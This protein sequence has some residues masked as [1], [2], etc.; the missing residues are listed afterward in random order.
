MADQLAQHAAFDLVDRMNDLIRSGTTD[1]APSLMQVPLEHYNSQERH[2]RELQALFRTTPLCAAPSAA[3]ANPGDFTTRDVLD[4]SLLISRDAEGE[5]HVVLNYCTHRGAII[6]TGEGC[7]KRHSCPYH[8]WTFDPS[9]TLVGLPGAKGFDELDR[10]TAGL[11]KLPTVEAHG[12][13]WCSLDTNGSID[14]DSELGD[15][16]AELD[17]WGYDNFWKVATYDH[18]FAANWKTT[19]EA[20][21]ETYHFPYVHGASIGPGVVTNTATFDLFADRHH[22]IG[23]P[24][25]PMR[26][27]A[28]GGAEFDPLWQTSLLYWKC[29]DLMLANTPMGVEVIQVTP[30]LNVN[31]TRLRHIMLARSAPTTDE[32]A[33]IALAMSVPAANAITLEDGPTLTTCGRGLAEGQHGYATIGRNEPGVQNVHNQV[34]RALGER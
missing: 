34:Q 16:S 19:M 12:F 2:E 14:I 21:S 33:E 20:F 15:F 5:A 11:V 26:A 4:R 10:S 9:G 30:T 29:P 7:T 24:L 3:L 8:G 31:E 27:H 32:E 18:V 13:I 22:R 1:M 25:T 23:T 28:E 17:R 6:A